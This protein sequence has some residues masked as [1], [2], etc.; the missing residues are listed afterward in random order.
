[1]T[2]QL[3]QRQIDRI[4]TELQDMQPTP[5]PSVTIL[6]EPATDSDTFAAFMLDVQAARKTHDLVLVACNR[7]ND[8]RV[9]QNIDRV[10][11]FVHAF[12]A[13]CHNARLTFTCDMSE[14]ALS[15]CGNVFTP[16]RIAYC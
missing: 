6:L 16:D 7:H 2:S 15:C 4:K 13:L 1:M 5:P 8:E 3:L 12:A 9:G 10:M 11:Y 14:F